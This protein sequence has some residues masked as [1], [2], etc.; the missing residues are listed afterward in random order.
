MAGLRSLFRRAPVASAEPAEPVTPAGLPEWADL[1]PM[2]R[3]VV[4]ALGTPAAS[5]S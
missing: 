5:S 1:P 2:P 4:D 3:T